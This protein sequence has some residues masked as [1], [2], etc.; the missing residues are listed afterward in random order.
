MK[1]ATKAQK[2]HMSRVAS[3]GCLIC[4]GP[5]TIHHCGTGAGG[6]RDHNKVIPLCWEHHLGREGVDGKAMSKR[7]WQEKYGSEES[8]LA[9]VEFE[10]K[11]Q[12][13]LRV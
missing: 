12:E 13:R 3:L 9:Q 1:A 2:A 8:L 10:L 4:R 6:R 11:K 5:A 7:A